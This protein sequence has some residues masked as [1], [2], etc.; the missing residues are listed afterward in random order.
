MN[1]KP[2][3]YSKDA[4]DIEVFSYNFK[5]VFNSYFLKFIFI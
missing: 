2:Q 4:P 5:N 1:L 3:L